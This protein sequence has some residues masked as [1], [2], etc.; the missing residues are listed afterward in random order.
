MV[1]LLI[2]IQLKRVQFSSPPYK[3]QLQFNRKK[4]S[5]CSK[6]F[7]LTL[8]IK[9]KDQIFVWSLFFCCY[10]FIKTFLFRYPLFIKF[11]LK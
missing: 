8:K 9:K 6:T 4:S 7:N 10:I 5:L 2:C 11:Y 1:K 3:I